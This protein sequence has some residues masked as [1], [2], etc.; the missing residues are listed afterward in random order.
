MKRPLIGVGVIVRKG[1]RILLGKRRNSHGD[2]AWQFPGGHLEWFETPEQCAER[3]V[4]EEAGIS[5]KDLSIG[6]HTNDL[7]VEEDRH[8]VT[9]YVLANHAFGEPKVL[10]PEKCERWDW[11][12]WE[13]LPI[14]LFLPIRNLLK[15]QFNPFQKKQMT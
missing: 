14:P 8:Y 3:E 7:F 11:F 2:G 13:N 10:E 9:L 12:E 6:P 4:K 5:I 15:Q 1:N